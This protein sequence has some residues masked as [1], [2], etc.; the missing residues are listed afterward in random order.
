MITHAYKTIAR[1]KLMHVQEH[2]TIVFVMRKHEF[3]RRDVLPDFMEINVIVYV[4]KVVKIEYVSEEMVDVKVVSMGG[5][6]KHATKDV[7]GAHRHAIRMMEI[8]MVM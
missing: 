6:E 2:V 8:V 7:H 5:L 4:V 3:V 1:Q